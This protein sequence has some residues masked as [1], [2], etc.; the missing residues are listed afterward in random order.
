[1]HTSIRKKAIALSLMLLAT[2]SAWADWEMIS[3][4]HRANFYIDPTTI[5][6]DG[7]FRKVWEVQNLKVRHKDGE[8][9]WRTRNEYDCINE[10]QRILSFS[11]HSGPVA[12]GDVLQIGR[13]PGSWSDVAPG[14]SGDTILRIVCGE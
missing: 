7:N 5:R 13:E 11:T 10:R 2:S 8:K 4:T 14:T 3:E 9:S 1:M 12:T 6:K